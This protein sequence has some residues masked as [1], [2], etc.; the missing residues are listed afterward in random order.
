MN[1]AMLQL[2]ALA[3]LLMFFGS[4]VAVPW[5]IGR[6]PVDYFLSHWKQ[7]DESRRRH[8]LAQV[9]IPVLRNLV[10]CV[11]L[12]AGVAM[13]LLPGQGLLT[14]VIG[15]CL[16]DFPGKRKVLD[17]LVGRAAIQQGLNWI[18]RKQRKGEFI[19][20]GAKRVSLENKNMNKRP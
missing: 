15:L 1:P 16:M 14:M 5:L 4:L 3:S 17:W 11:L 12:M 20:K 18:R 7:V 19:F 6:L 2:L 8:P 9:L 10:G 13:L